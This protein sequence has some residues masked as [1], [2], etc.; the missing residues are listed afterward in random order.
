[1]SLDTLQ[2]RLVQ[3]SRELSR[4]RRRRA[5][6]RGAVC[7]ALVVL[8]TPPALAA[9]GV[10]QPTLGDGE[11]PAPAISADAPPPDQLALLGVLRREQTEADRGVAT[12]YA[13]KFVD[14]PG[15]KGVR[16]DSIRLLAQSK[17]DR[18]VVLVPV[19]RYEHR[20]PGEI[21]EELRKRVERT[22]DDAL[23][24]YHL[25]SV[26][27]AGV[28]CYSSADVKEGRAWGMLGHRSLWIVPD[29]VASVRTEYGDRDPVVAAVRDNA[30]IF[31]APEG[32]VDE[33]RTVWLD[34]DGRSV[35]VIE[36]P[37]GGGTVPPPPA[38]A[39][40]ARHSGV[41]ERVGV[42]GSGRAAQ[43]E[44]R[45]RMREHGYYV[46]LQRPA[47]AGKRRVR[48]FAGGS[49][50]EYRM[51][52]TPMFGDLS[53]ASWCPGVYRG[54]VRAPRALKPAGTFSFR[55]R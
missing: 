24:I 29:G 44:L 6:R 26:D 16:T 30:A 53:N 46:V 50:D 10:W 31:T 52:V 37:T 48:E 41:V 54:I 17:E 2:Q 3:A 15:L 28:A 23:C 13:L 32:R 4:A 36:R 14:S 5:R 11:G 20:L 45:L 9:T 34:A 33:R 40:G 19:E 7:A 38:P 21:P 47:C 18:G 39:L 43:Y 49:S 35:R 27:G 22:I 55:V 8:V 12:R 42:R 51:P 1:M 25:D